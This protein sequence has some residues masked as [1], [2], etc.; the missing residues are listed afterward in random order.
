LQLTCVVDIAEL[1]GLNTS[2][3]SQVFL[4]GLDNKLSLAVHPAIKQSPVFVDFD[5]AAQRA[6]RGKQLLVKAILG[7]ANRP[8]VLDATA[9]LGRDSAVLAAFGYSVT[10]V[11]QNPIV[12]ALLQ[13]GL[14]RAPQLK[15]L[16]LS[17]A[18]NAFEAM[19]TPHDVV[20]LDPMFE[21]SGKAA[22]AKKDLQLLQQLVGHGGQ[23]GQVGSKPSELLNAALNAAI[24]RVVVKRALKA[25]SLTATSG[26]IPTNKVLGKAVRYDAYA[27]KKYS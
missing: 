15:N 4:R 12:R 5:E 27:L 9:G 7:G 18:Q 10:M 16:T 20:Y 24:Y 23:Q 19:Q 13:D 11:E 1:E 25:P 22:K 3:N 14:A 26:V 17:S 2:R 6:K 8:A 21:E